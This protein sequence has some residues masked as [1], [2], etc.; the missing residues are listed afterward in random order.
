MRGLLPSL[1]GCFPFSA[2][3]L[4][5]QPRPGRRRGATEAAEHR[6]RISPCIGPQNPPGGRLWQRP[7]KSQLVTCPPKVGKKMALKYLIR[8]LD[9]GRATLWR[10]SS[11][12]GL[13]TAVCFTRRSSSRAR[14][15]SSSPHQTLKKWRCFYISL[16]PPPSHH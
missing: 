4:P 5:R 6:P 2:A 10:L 13:P 14:T 1:P 12:R 16:S 3:S 8:V 11:Y 9:D 15:A 7:R